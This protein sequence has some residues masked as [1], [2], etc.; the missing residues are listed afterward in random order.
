MC[1]VCNS[2]VEQL[3]FVDTNICTQHL[4]RYKLALSQIN[5]KPSNGLVLMVFPWMSSVAEDSTG[6]NRRLGKHL[7]AF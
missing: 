3:C 4:Q 2:L 1:D 6:A 7:L 5:F